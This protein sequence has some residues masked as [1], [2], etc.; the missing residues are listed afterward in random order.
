MATWNKMRQLHPTLPESS[1]E[2]RQVG[3]GWAHKTATIG[4]RASIGQWASVG[5]G[6]TIDR[7]PIYIAGTRYPSFWAG[8]DMVGSGCITKPLQ[9]WLA[10]VEACARHHG[11]TTDQQR[12]YQLHVEHIAAWMRLYG[13]A[14]DRKSKS[15][16]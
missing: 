16:G 15:N 9:W 6:C 2:W 10:N 4:Q 7:T 14:N 11:Y 3:S 8:G 13:F 1:N 5:D 12:E